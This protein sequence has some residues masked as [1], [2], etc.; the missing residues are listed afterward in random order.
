VD[1]L[2]ADNGLEARITS[3]QRAWSSFSDHKGG[4]SRD[5]ENTDV[6]PVFA[7]LAVVP[8]VAPVQESSISVYI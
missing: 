8:E 6:D 2:D 3:P 4:F 1:N 7:R 5:T